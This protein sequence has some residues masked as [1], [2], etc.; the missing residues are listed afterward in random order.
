VENRPKAIRTTGS[1]R[2]D[3][4]E[5]IFVAVLGAS[6][7]TFAEAS[8]TQSLPDWIAVHVNMLAFIGGV[9][10]QIVSDNLKSGTVHHSF[11]QQSRAAETCQRRRCRPP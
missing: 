5:N 3:D 9:L 10:R 11:R 8:W 6:S 4:P 7:Y 1:A 2:R